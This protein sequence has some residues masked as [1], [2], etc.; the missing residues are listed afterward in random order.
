MACINMRFTS[1][2]RI[3]HVSPTNRYHR[4]WYETTSL[5][6]VQ[7]VIPSSKVATSY[8]QGPKIAAVVARQTTTKADIQACSKAID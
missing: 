6:Q 2:I 1:Q 3:A 5:M 4:S 7:V 8:E